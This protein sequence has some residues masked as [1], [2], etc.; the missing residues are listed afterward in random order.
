[1]ECCGLT[2]L[3][4]CFELIYGI[5]I[6]FWDLVSQVTDAIGEYG[7]FTAIEC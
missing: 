7:N 1:M 4:I 3:W 5:L 2:Q 6:L